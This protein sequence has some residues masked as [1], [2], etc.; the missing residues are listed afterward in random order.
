M[1]ATAT[2]WATHQSLT[3]TLQ[4]IHRAWLEEARRMLEPALDFAADFW[5]R[6]GAMQYLSDD[7][8]EQFRLEHGLVNELCP[9]LPAEASERLLRGGDRILHLRLELARLQRRGRRVVTSHLALAT[10]DLL[11]Q[12]AIW[13]AEIETAAQ[14]VRPS[15]LPAAAA[16]LIEQLEDGIG[17]E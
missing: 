13:C 2:A 9:F 7:F 10:R 4:P 5:T 15:D 16:G 11:E 17:G 6:W 3:D 8:R 14:D 1:R 12:I